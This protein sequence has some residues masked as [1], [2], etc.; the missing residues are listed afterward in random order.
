MGAA[1]AAGIGAAGAIG[2]AAIGSGSKGGSSGTQNKVSEPWA[3][4][5]GYLTNGF[6]QAQDLFN[7]GQ[8][9][10][11]YQGNT[12]ALQNQFQQQAINSATGAAGPGGTLAG[13][14]GQTA[15]TAGALQGGAGQFM[16][17]AQGIAQNGLG[18]NYGTLANIL[19]GYAN[20]STP[21]L[22]INPQLSG[23]LTS[24]AVNGA[25]SLNGFTQGQQTVM[26]RALEDPTQQLSSQAQAYMN[27]S[28]VQSAVNSTNALIDQTLNEQTVPGLN[29]RAAMGGNLNSSRAG[30]AESMANE[31]AALAKGNAD[32][33]ILNNAFNTGLSTAAA[34]RNA[35]LTTGMYAANSGLVD[36]TGLAQG[37]QN[38]LINQGEFGTNTA[39]QAA[40]LGLGG[41]NSNVGAQLAANGQL[42]QGVGM[43][44]NAGTAAAQQAAGNFGLLSGA[45]QLQQQGEQA[46]LTNPYNQWQI[47]AQYPWQNLD[48]Y[49]NIVG[50]ANWG[51][52]NNQA[53][54]G[55]QVQANTPGL[56][57]ALGSGSALAGGL[58]DLFSNWDNNSQTPSGNG[59]QV[60]TNQGS[61]SGVDPS[62]WATAPGFSFGGQGGFSSPFLG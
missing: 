30:M 45:G 15:G 36:N 12:T 27:S 5:A 26:N 37:Q 9:L 33:S 22:S 2:S 13:L 8:A 38:A 28:P 11:P 35:G 4:Q 24:A 31:N 16:Q 10:G 51:G 17:N 55:S 23:A 61:L 62:T 20:G 18:G 42:G 53:T 50:G 60:P 3:P 1:A 29:R 43:G 49:W 46:L 59:T 21:A 6:A 34:E 14:P 44:V 40:Q 56:A 52:V 32:S 48:N 58:T 57:S 47:S 54:Q 7:Q 25:N 19:N 39:L 41:L